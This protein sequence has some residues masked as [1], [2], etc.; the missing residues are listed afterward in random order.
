MLDLLQ[1]FFH[2]YGYLAMF[3][4]LILCG[5]GLPIPED[6]TLLAGGVVVGLG[7]ADL[8]YMIIT[9]MLGVLLGDL[10]V[11]SLGYFFGNKIRKT[12]LV[13]RLLTVKKYTI[14]QEKFEKYGNGAIF[15]GRFFPGLRTPMFFTAGLSR[16]VTYLQFLLIDGSAA[17]VSVPLWIWIGYIF[18]SNKALLLI[19]SRN[20]K[21]FIFIL[22]VIFF[23][24]FA[25]R[26]YFAR[27]RRD[28]DDTIN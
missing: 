16:R 17:I 6:I 12:G 18:A 27:G 10:V 21:L 7:N 5:F 9:G 19:I 13:G 20:F 24:F 3:L 22:I 8:S 28:T 11:F 1:L 26:W 2:S 14:L 25:F 15:I 4:V 23:S